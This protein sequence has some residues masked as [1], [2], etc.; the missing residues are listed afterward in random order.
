LLRGTA[1]SERFEV[2][3][4]GVIGRDAGKAQFLLDHP[5]VSR[6][7]A[8]LALDGGR[9]VLADLGSAN[10]TYVNGRRIARPVPLDRGDHVDIGPFSLRFDGNGLVSRSRSNNVE[11]VARGLGR[12]V[13]E[14]GTGKSLALLDDISLVIRP[15]EFVCVLGP[16]GSGK[17]TLLA[18]LS[19]RN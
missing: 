18:L 17:S 1:R 19:G 9:V 16:S 7:H 3:Q 14:R 6:L 2:G 8:S 10:G 11:L 12:V 15:R 5:H 4:G 13:R